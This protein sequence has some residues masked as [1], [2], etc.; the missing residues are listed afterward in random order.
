M[1]RALALTLLFA[2][3]AI[4]AAPEK[5]F[6]A[7]SR[8]VNA[9]RAKNYDAAADALGRAVAEMPAE[10]GAARARNE[11]ITYTPHF[12]LGIAKFNLGD[13]DGALREWKTPEEQGAAQ[14]S[15]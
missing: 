10:S 6:E 5:W 11:I 9:V 3:P 13:V 15:A 14:N 2:L 8:G 1:R 12:W 7:Y 4:A